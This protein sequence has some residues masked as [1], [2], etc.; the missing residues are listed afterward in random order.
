VAPWM[1]ETTN[2]Q[3]EKLRRLLAEIEAK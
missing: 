1:I 3:L 2:T